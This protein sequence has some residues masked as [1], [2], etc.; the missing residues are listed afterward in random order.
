VLAPP[1]AVRSCK[2]NCDYCASKNAE[3]ARER[4]REHEH[5]YSEPASQSRHCDVSSNSKV[6]SR[7]AQ[8]D[9]ETACHCQV[10]VCGRRA[11]GK[12]QGEG[13]VT[14]KSFSCSATMVRYMDLIMV[15]L[16]H[17][18]LLADSFHFLVSFNQAPLLPTCEMTNRKVLALDPLLQRSRVL[19]GAGQALTVT[20]LLS[21]SQSSAKEVD[22]SLKGTKKD[23]RFEACLSRCLY[24]CTKAK[25]EQQKS[26][27]ECLPEC[28]KRCATTKEQLLTGKPLKS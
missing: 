27:S 4:E 24:D 1:V 14:V 2:C 19:E 17:Q 28:K 20:F 25:G 16:P 23:P 18:L 3:R 6:T 9:G 13:N 5:C 7:D 22:P 10:V 26:R 15:L 11:H 8:R 12:G 21:P